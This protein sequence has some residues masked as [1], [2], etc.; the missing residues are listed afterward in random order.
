MCTR[1]SNLGEDLIL[2][3]DYVDFTSLLEKAGQERILNAWREEALF[4]VSEEENRKPRIKL[5]RKQKREQQRNHHRNVDPKNSPAIICTITGDFRQCQYEDL[6]LK[7]AWHHALHPDEHVV[8]TGTAGSRL[9]EKP[10]SGR[11]VARKE[12]A[13]ESG[14][15]GDDDETWRKQEDEAVAEQTSWRPGRRN[16]NAPA[17]LLEKRGTLRCVRVTA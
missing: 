7:H 4:G 15:G 13:G 6:T 9:G 3:T 8:G 11:G 17:T 14:A 10:A 5:S 16:E 2:G 1:R 12:E